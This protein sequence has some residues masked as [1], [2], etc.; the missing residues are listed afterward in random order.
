MHRKIAETLAEE[1]RQ[2]FVFV[3]S[4]WDETFVCVTCITVV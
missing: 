4:E 3:N 1:E 2:E